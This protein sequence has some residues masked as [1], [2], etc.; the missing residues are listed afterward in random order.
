[1]QLSYTNL[2]NNVNST[3]ARR[4]QKKRAEKITEKEREKNFPKLIKDTNPHIH[5]DQ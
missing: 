4:K 2:K 5:K 1:M 3:S